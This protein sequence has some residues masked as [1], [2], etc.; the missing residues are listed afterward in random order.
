MILQWERKPYG[1][2]GSYAD[3]AG[4]GR[5][6]TMLNYDGTWEARFNYGSD[7]A[8]YSLRGLSDEAEAKRTCEVWHVAAQVAMRKAG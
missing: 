5:Y 7:T 8:C 1:S 3:D 2:R 4:Q 6:S